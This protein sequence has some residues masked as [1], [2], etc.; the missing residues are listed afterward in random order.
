M[1]AALLP[2]LLFQSSDLT[3]T[4]AKAQA[5]LDKG[6]AMAAVKILEDAGAVNSKNTDALTVLGVAQLR[7][8][9]ALIAAG[10]LRG[11]H[12]NDGFLEAAWTLEAAVNAGGAAPQAYVQW[13][14]AL[15]NGGD[16][17]NALKATENG[18][19]A[20]PGNEAVRLQ[21]SR[22]LVTEAARYEGLGKTEKRDTTWK[23]AEDLLQDAVESNKKSVTP[24]V[25]L[26]ELKRLQ[27]AATQNASDAKDAQKAWGM[28]LNRNAD[29]VNL[30]SM[31]QWLR[32]DAIPLL[33]GLIK[34]KGVDPTLVWYQGYAAYLEWP[35]NWADVRRYFEL[36][37]EL[38]PQ[39]TD[40]WYFLADAAMTEGVRLNDA[41]EEK[42]ASNAFL[43]SAKGWANYFNDFG[44]NYRASVQAGTDRGKQ[45]VE[46]M[47]WLAGKAVARR[48][49]ESALTLLYWSSTVMPKDVEVW[50]N[51]AL[52]ERDFGDP[53]KALHAY[54]RA[55]ELSPDDPQILN[56]WAV[57]LHYY[58]KKE[59]EKALKLYADAILL[60]EELLGS[61][62]LPVEDTARIETALRDSR[63]N[64]KRLK[65]GIRKN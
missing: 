49:S 60:A 23:E 10:K 6:D 53:S 3:A 36:V 46:Q 22:I 12:I 38:N 7:R 24:C 16:Y 35:R 51:I 14:E 62:N 8:T 61:G 58:L 19:R 18:L 11:L 37:L 63:N 31:V 59:D 15:L 45:V 65:K 55:G 43:Y 52:L 64:L 40:V 20:H 29:A 2:L 47:K 9:E 34:E 28:A 50:N 4:A 25:K 57:I 54:E 42:K 13:S 26:G 21:K 56:D 32:S 48:K 5:F 41:G 17:K 44:P 39:Q 1:L 27:F 33:D 30:S